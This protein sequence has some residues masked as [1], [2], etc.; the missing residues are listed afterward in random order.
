MGSVAFFPTL[1]YSKA[2]RRNVKPKK[3]RNGAI[4]TKNVETMPL[5]YIFGHRYQQVGNRAMSKL[6]SYRRLNLNCL[7][8]DSARI[9]ST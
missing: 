6:A 4:F 8:A 9:A 1:F 5:T 7:A 3:L 2:C